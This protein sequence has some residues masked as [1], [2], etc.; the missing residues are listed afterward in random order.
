MTRTSPRLAKL[1][2][3][4][5]RDGANDIRVNGLRTNYHE[6]SDAHVLFTNM[7]NLWR[8]VNLL[9]QKAPEVLRAAVWLQVRVPADRVKA[10]PLP[11]FF[12][13]ERG[14]IPGADI[15]VLGTGYQITQHWRK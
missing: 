9:R 12:I 11:G 4:T 6:R 14:I 2:T 8:L 1:V 3:M 5:D 15:R 7:P 13:V 10:S